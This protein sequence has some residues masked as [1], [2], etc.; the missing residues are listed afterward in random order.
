[1]VASYRSNLLADFSERGLIHEVSA[2]LDERVAKDPS[3]SAYIGFDPS[4]DSLHVGHLMGV[5]ALRRLQLAGG[6]P[7]AKHFFRNED[8]SGIDATRTE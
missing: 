1:M 7:I 8:Q 6:R 2:G 5:L 3:I 4:A